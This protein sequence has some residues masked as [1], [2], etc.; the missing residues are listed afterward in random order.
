[1][2]P[3]AF[4]ILKVGH[5]LQNEHMACRTAPWRTSAFPALVA[6]I[7]HPKAGA[8]LFDTGYAPRF[9]EATARWPE[10]L[11]RLTT[12]VTLPEK[13]H[14][15][16]QLAARG[17]TP[18]D[19]KTVLV[20][21]F[22]ADHVCGLD[23]FPTARVVCTR[24]GLAQV[25]SVGRLAGVRRGLLPAVVPKDLE[26]RAR[27]IE[28]APEIRLSDDLAPFEKGRDISGDGSLIAI[29][30]PGHAAGQ[31]GALFTAGDGRRI[32]LAADAAFSMR[33][34]RENSP[35]LAIAGALLG[36]TPAYAETLR[37]L[38]ELHRRNPGILII[39]SHCPERTQELVR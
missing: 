23:D 35:P 14:L 32:L 5:C 1:M 17:I 26:T 28:D 29:D 8:I 30:L 33:A 12:P 15:V 38:H 20:S 25:R 10:R 9:S 24:E 36:H 27:L 11:Y 16:A 7:H 22:H 18:G 37:R 19:V 2:I 3:L 21:H 4:E 31:F 6:L 39:P 34:I 13:E